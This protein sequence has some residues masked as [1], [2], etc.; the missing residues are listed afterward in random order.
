MK[1]DAVFAALAST[2][3]RQILAYLSET[4]LTAGEIAE[5]F[6]MS[7]PSLSKHLQI[8]ENAGLVS[9]EKRGQ[10]VH[11]QLANDNMLATL[12]NFLVDFCPVGGPIKK[13]SAAL[14]RT[15]AQTKSGS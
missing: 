1:A 15:R 11:Y 10:F 5:R 9:R 7:K 2:P 4:S 13:E 8:L 14:A 6:A 3:R 12:H